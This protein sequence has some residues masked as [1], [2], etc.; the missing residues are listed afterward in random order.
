MIVEV[1]TGK[2]SLY[3]VGPEHAIEKEPEP[4]PDPDVMI[5]LR[6]ALEDALQGSPEFDPPRS[7]LDVDT[8]RQLRELGYLDA[9]QNESSP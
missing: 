9:E 4:N 5:R 8:A 6:E 3:R 2:Q 1:T 7:E